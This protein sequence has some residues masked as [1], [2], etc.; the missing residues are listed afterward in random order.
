VRVL[1]I[2]RTYR[3]IL[4]LSEIATVLTRHGF[5]D[6][7][8]RIKL[9][10]HVPFLDRLVRE[11]ISRVTGGPVLPVSE[12]AAR[13]AEQLGG[14]FVKFG[15]M[16]SMRP[17]LLPED[18][19]REFAR[20]Q[21]RVAPFPKEQARAQI[22]KQLGRPVEE[23][24]AS[25]DD[26]P[27]ASASIAQ[28]HFAR[29]PDGT[30]VVVK[31][32][33]PEEQVKRILADLDLLE[34]LAE[35]AERHI[36]ELRLFRPVLIVE[37]FR[38]NMRRELD[39]TLEATTTEKFRKAFADD[40]DVVIPEVYWDRTGHTVLTLSRLGGAK[41]SDPAALEA[42]G[43]DRKALA[44]T[45]GRTFM[46]QFFEMGF[47]HADPH[48][49]NIFA[50]GAGRIALLDFGSVGHLTPELKGQL[51]TTLLGL[52][53]GEID[54]MVSII[55]EMGL[56][57]DSTDLRG[58]KLDLLEVIHRY[59]G[60]PAGHTDMAALFQEMVR[61]AR[62]H[63]AQLP[64]DFVMLGRSLFM[65]V[66]LCQ[67]LDPGFNMAAAVAPYV[68]SLLKE[69]LSPRNILKRLAYSAY[70]VG[71][72]A[73]DLPRSLKS[74]MHKAEAGE[75]QVNF[76]H[77]GLGELTR[78]IQRSSTRLSLSIVTGSVLVGSSML[79]AT[80]TPPTLTE[81]HGSLPGASALGL[82]GFGLALVLGLWLVWT[83]LRS[84]DT[85]P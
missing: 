85:P 78:G 25:L 70:S 50:Q 58:V 18:Y 39:F 62:A 28:V 10:R 5:G 14:T 38:R 67:Q 40:P 59:Y 7:F 74:L 79:L 81:L 80:G 64:R 22:E 52:S 53:Q 1:G 35:L 3:N 37:E 9:F 44:A 27:A 8:Q 54:L 32:R 36:P 46:R 2:G 17:D 71:T 47:F 12:R 82:L 68:R 34:D 21:D 13:A 20:L 76:Q 29:L 60:L 49:G 11:R 72:L 55:A 77:R 31:V 56:F 24:Y 73:H 23:L 65:V 57:G 19:V 6:L 51:A 69:K 61:L 30:D 84:T 33:R 16:L 66:S 41:L 63:D 42:D 26:T 4:R 75:L 83:G 48:P 43:V 45:V 15:Q